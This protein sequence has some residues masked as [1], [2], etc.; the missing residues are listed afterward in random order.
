MPLTGFYEATGRQSK[1]ERHKEICYGSY[2]IKYLYKDLATLF[3]LDFR[4]QG[5]MHSYTK[6]LSFNFIRKRH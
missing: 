3:G 1:L 2:K 5:E 4:K 6:R